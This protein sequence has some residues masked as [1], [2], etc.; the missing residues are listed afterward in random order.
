VGFPKTAGTCWKT[1]LPKKSTFDNY[2]VRARFCHHR[3]AH[4]AFECPANSKMMGKKTNHPPAI[5]DITE[6]GQLETY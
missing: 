4:N 3:Q 2:E 5:E 1:I 6:R